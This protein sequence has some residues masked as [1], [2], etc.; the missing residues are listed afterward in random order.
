MIANWPANADM[1]LESMHNAATLE[2]YFDFAYNEWFVD[3]DGD[4]ENEEDEEELEEFEISYENM[5]LS[6]GI[7]GLA[8][9]LLV[10]TLIIYFIAKLCAM[11][12]RWCNKIVYSLKDQLFYGAWIRFMIE[13]NLDLTHN[14]VFFLYIS[15]GFDDL[16]QGFGSSIRI[17]ILAS[18]VM[19]PIA[20]IAF[21]YKWRSQ[22]NEKDFQDKYLSIYQGI[23][24]EHFAAL[25]YTSVFSIRRLFLVLTLLALHNHD[26]WLILAYNVIQSAYFIYMATVKP[27][28][29]P[30]HNW[31]E[32]FNEL[33]I[34]V[35]QYLIV[36]FVS[37]IINP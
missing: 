30:I 7:F 10:L 5:Y 17:L 35:I 31:L 15:G 19:W 36:F 2:N 6:L 16:N 29:A 20:L 37:S 34:I 27:H 11:R 12:F 25:I 13:S 18:T 8:I 14:C 9:V 28:E 33:C 4:F 23:K 22:V 32:I 1:M 24:T 3:F 21:L 26:Y